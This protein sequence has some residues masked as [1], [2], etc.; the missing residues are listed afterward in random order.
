MGD[1]EY[2]EKMERKEEKVAFYKLFS[3]ADSKDVVLM[4]VGLVA[5]V[6]SGLSMPLM[7]FIFGKLSNAFG[8]ANRDNVVHDVSKVGQLLA[9]SGHRRYC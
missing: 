5:A 9:S 7:S 2:M 4:L 3:F 6:A 8:V 1:S